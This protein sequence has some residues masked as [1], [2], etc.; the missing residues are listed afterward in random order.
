MAIFSKPVKEGFVLCRQISNRLLSN[1]SRV[2]EIHNNAWSH[3]KFSILRNLIEFKDH[4]GGIRGP[5]KVVITPQKVLKFSLLLFYFIIKYPERNSK[6]F[7]VRR[8]SDRP[9]LWTSH[10][11]NFS[12]DRQGEGFSEWPGVRGESASLLTDEGKES[13][14][15]IAVRGEKIFMDIWP[16][17][18][19]VVETLTAREEFRVHKWRVIMNVYYDVYS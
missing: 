2:A 17:T 6:E 13:P 15:E 16:T 3:R 1:G 4:Y 10:I 9:I 14:N 5:A 18:Q 11:I 19:N 8:R 12:T 7:N